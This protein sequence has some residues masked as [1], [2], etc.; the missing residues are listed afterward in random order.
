MKKLVIVLG[1]VVATALLVGTVSAALPGPG[2]WTSFQVQNVGDDTATLAYTA[3]WQVGQGGTAGDDT[4]SEMGTVTMTAGSALIY[5]PGVATPSLAAGQLS[6]NTGDRHLP[7]GF[8]GAV[9]VSAD[10]PIVAVVQVGNNPAGSVGTTGGRAIAFYQ[11]TGG[12]SVGDMINFPSMKHNYYGQTTAFYIQAAGGAANIDATFHTSVCPGNETEEDK[13]FPLTDIDIPMG[14]TYLLDPSAASVPGTGNGCLGSLTVEANSG[15]IAGVVIETQHAANPGTFALSTKG[16]APA[17]SDTTVVA[18]TNKTAFYGG[19]TGW[20]LLNTSDSLT[21]T[22]AVTFTVTNIEPGSLGHTAGITVGDQY[23]A[24]VEIG[25]GGAYLFSEPN[26]N[27][28]AATPLGGAPTMDEGLFFAGTAVSDVPLV[29]VVNENN[30]PNRLVYSSFGANA[31]TTKVA[32]PLVKEYW[33]G[34]LTGL[35]VQNVGNDTA[36]VNLTYDCKLAAGGRDVYDV[37]PYDID[38]GAAMSFIRL[39]DAT[40]WGGVLVESSTQCAVTVMSDGEPIVALAQ[41]S[42]TFDTRNYEGFN[43]AP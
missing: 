13:D 17:D 36:E 28:Y 15:S 3:Y 32:A 40:R 7:S 37:G 42:S 8:A 24:D 21:A 6:F 25:P 43:L 1:V 11:G 30:G 12:E 5:N 27:Y 22:V 9:Q 41:E 19:R 26:G 23:R 38:A 16:F 20:Q 4:Y 33:Y 35:A 2:W 10:Q 29:G 34:G 31:A 18:P 39:S 14:K